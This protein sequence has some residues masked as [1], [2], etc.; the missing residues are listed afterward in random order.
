MNKLLLAFFFCCIMIS[1]CRKSSDPISTTSIPSDSTAFPNHVMFE[2]DGH[3]SLN[4][5]TYNPALVGD[6]AN[7]EIDAPPTGG[8]WSLKLHKA[9]T[10][11]G[12]NNVTRTFTKISSGIYYLKNA[13]SRLVDDLVRAI[14]SLINPRA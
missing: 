9:D 1:A 4:G 2:K 5:W 14:P 7:F 11:H 8:T 12:S 3:G 13:G 6:T 10:P